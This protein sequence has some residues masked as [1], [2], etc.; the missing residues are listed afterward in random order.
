MTHLATLKPTQ[1]ETVWS[2]AATGR[3]PMH[4]GVRSS[5]IYRVVG[6]TPAL[7]LLPDYCFAQALVRFGFLWEES[8]TAGSGRPAPWR[9]LS[10]QGSVSA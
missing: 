10:D 2:A 5:A 3:G 4:N 8:H 1:A 9:V 6:L 7:T